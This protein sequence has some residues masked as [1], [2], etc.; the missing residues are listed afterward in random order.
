MGLKEKLEHKG[1]IMKK[2]K[3]L[4]LMAIPALLVSLV[5]CSSASTEAKPMT[6]EEACDRLEENMTKAPDQVDDSPEEIKKF[7]DG[8]I[9]GVNNEEVTDAWESMT[10]IML[11]ISESFES[12]GILKEGAEMPDLQKLEDASLKVDELCGFPSSDSS[13]VGDDSIEIEEVEVP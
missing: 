1:K 2:T 10:S 5:G 9:D 8:L 6:V 4:P 11:D 3:L 12:D 13:L 7:M